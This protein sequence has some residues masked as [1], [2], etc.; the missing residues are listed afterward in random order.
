M[1]GA[2]RAGAFPGRVASAAGQV[3]MWDARKF[4][5]RVR[6]LIRASEVR[7]VCAQLRDSQIGRV[8]VP[9]VGAIRQVHA[10]H[11][12]DTV[13]KGLALDRLARAY[14]S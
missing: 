12:P 3:G 11:G 1:I 10:P 5:R 9:R 8:V 13:C 6:I 7:R 14:Y 4:G 2:V